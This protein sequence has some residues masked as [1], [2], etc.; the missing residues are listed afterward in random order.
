MKQTKPNES[1]INWN[2]SPDDFRLIDLIAS[3]Y[4]AYIKDHGGSADNFQTRM[5]I[6]ACHLNGKPLQLYQMYL[7]SIEALI[8]DV[9]IIISTI[10][11]STGKLQNSSNNLLY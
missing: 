8:H 11:R 2:A 10:D 4:C 1:H 7:G 6:T 3:V 9:Y 5:D